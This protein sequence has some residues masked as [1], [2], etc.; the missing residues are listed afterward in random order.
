V[1]T[2][3]V[4]IIPGNIPV[5]DHFALKLPA[6]AKPVRAGINPNGGGA[7]LWYT[8]EAEESEIEERYFVVVLNGAQ[9]EKPADHRGM[10]WAGV[11]TF[12]LFELEG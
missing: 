1:I 10:W 8:C 7:A 6:G 12:H 11:S 9:L 2:I 4:E 5:G 3:Q